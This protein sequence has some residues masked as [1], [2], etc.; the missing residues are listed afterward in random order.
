MFIVDFFKTTSAVKQAKKFVKAHE[1][2]VNT[3]KGLISKIQNAITWFE[4]H[5]ADIE[6]KIADAKATVEKLKGFLNK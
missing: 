6:A 3:V 1:E 2:T 5:K 4:N